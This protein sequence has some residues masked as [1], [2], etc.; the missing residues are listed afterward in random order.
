MGRNYL[1]K[2]LIV[3]QFA[4]AIFLII[5]TIA[6]N[7]QLNF[8]LSADLGYDTKNL[9]RMDIPVNNSSDKLPALF[10]NE[11]LNKAGVVNVAA[12]HG[13]RNISGARVDGK[14]IIIEYNKIDD[15]Y[16]S[17]FKIPV[18]AGRNFSPEY[19]SDSLQSVV[20]NESFV[21]EAGWALNN[22]VG[23]TVKFGESRDNR[24]VT[25]VGVVKDRHFQSLKEKITPEV[26]SMEPGFNFGQIWVKIDP[27]NTPH[28]LSLLQ[29]TFRKLLP[30]YPYSYE[31]MDDINAKN[32]EMETK[33]KQIISIASILFVFISCIGLLGLV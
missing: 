5:G 9:V 3:L 25:V 2:G 21:K 22:A 26:F 16:L 17:T 33:W 32:Y 7:A 11:L 27:A 6:I 24:T 13:G 14:Q 19:S 28:T 12:R 15:R 18:I 20:V 30:Y 10:K 1:T 31:F 4:L 23:K 29:S 8:L